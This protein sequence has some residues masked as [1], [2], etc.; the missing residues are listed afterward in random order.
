VLRYRFVLLDVGGTLVGPRDSYGAV[1]RRV[2]GGLGLDLDTRRLDDAIRATADAVARRIP[3]GRDRFAHYPGGES[4]YW[5]RVVAEVLDRATGRE[6]APGLVQRA[7]DRLQQAFGRTD[8][9][10]VYDDV[11]PALRQLRAAGVRLG[12]V[13]NWDSRLPRLLDRLGLAGY[14]AAVGVSHLERVEK[15]DPA[16]FRL[17]LSRL[18]ADPRDA[19]HVGD[20]AELDLAGA[21]AAGIDGLLIDRDGS[22][23]GHETIR[24]LRDLERIA[25]GEDSRGVSRSRGGTA[26]RA[27]SAPS[28]GRSR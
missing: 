2:L 16:L 5:S 11:V 18:G 20:V 26:A 17:V 23:R 22:S 4:E 6:A 21:R 7:L 8:A 19:L 3:S 28:S 25:A 15:P 14:F 1:Y 24:D 10:H 9:W 12:V 13:S 27:S